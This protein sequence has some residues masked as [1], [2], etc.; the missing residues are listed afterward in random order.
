MCVYNVCCVAEEVCVEWRRGVAVLTVPLPSR[1]E[2]CRFTLRPLTSTVAALLQEMRDEDK[3]IDRAA[4]H[5]KG[6]KVVIILFRRMYTSR[7]L[8]VCV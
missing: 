8:F 5:D 6:E 3:G 1:R 7:A 2:R 4:L